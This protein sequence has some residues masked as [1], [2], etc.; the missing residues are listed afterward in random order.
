MVLAMLAEWC[1]KCNG[2]R[3]VMVGRLRRMVLA[4]EKELVMPLK[5]SSLPQCFR[6]ENVQVI[7]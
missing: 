3:N 1:L 7:A 6:F 5:W 4:R 2:A